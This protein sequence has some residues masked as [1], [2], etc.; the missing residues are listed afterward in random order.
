MVYVELL[1]MIGLKVIVSD[2]NTLW[3]LVTV[4]AKTTCNTVF[5]GDLYWPFYSVLLIIM[6]K[7]IIL[8]NVLMI[9]THS[10]QVKYPYHQNT[11]ASYRRPTLPRS[12][13][14]AFHLLT[15]AI[16]HNKKISDVQIH[17]ST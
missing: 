15:Y 4:F 2:D 10:S 9:L 8:S 3:M 16:I 11:T 6:L 1:I 12:I 13:V 14:Q 7:I 5:G 17:L